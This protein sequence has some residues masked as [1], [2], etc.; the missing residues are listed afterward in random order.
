MK[1]LGVD[2]SLVNTGVILLDDITGDWKIT[3][4]ELIVT[5]ASTLKGV[6]KN[7]DD[8]CRARDLWDALQ[9]W[10]DRADWL[11]IEIPQIAGANVQARSMWASGIA[12]GTLAAAKKP[13][14]W[15]TPKEVKEAIGNATAS[16][17]EMVE[18]AYKM[19]PDAPWPKRK[20]KGEMVPL[21]SNHH[22]ADALAA[23]HAGIKKGLDNCDSNLLR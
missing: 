2:P 3:D 19:Y 14:K 11:S 7:Y 13:M 6:R 23:A 12:L 10:F 16:K 4:M 5:K 21:E 8:F 9:P 20:F 15:L 1:I 22:L 18:W 17:E